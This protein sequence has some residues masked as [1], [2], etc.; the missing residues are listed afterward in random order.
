MEGQG[1]LNFV[2]LQCQHQTY[3]K[4]D[5]P[6]SIADNQAISVPE[7]EAY[8]Q[9]YWNFDILAIAGIAQ[10]ITANTRRKSRIIEIH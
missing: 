7:E 8:R 3:P 6:Y 9:S 10:D 1:P 5:H 2:Y 4:I